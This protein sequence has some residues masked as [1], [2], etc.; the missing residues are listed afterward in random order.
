MGKQDKLFLFIICTLGIGLVISILQ[1]E[2]IRIQNAGNIKDLKKDMEW[3]S[4]LDALTTKLLID[5]H[6]ILNP[7]PQKEC[8]KWC[9]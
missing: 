7:P 4:E 1:N 3:N 6:K 8:K 5:H 2:S 9:R